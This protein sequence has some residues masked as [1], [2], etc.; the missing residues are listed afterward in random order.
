MNDTVLEASDMLLLPDEE[1]ADQEAV[2]YWKFLIVDDD[3]DIHRVTKL[4]LERH[5]FEGRKLQFMS[6]YS[7]SE[8][9]G[10]LGEHP[11]IAVV[12]LDVVMEQDDSGLTL[13]KVL[14]EVLGNQ[15]VRIILRTGQPGQAPEHTVIRAYDISDYKEKTELTST[16]LFST[17][18]TSIR[19]YQF[20][21]GV[22]ADKETLEE[23]V[24]ERTRELELR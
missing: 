22:V 18:Y 3:R 2:R 6:A 1:P 8:A 13:V 12:L 24:R 17:V 15:L 19:T 5:M 9:I 7:A 11:D 4:V 16:K 10:F 20:L 14:R 23:K 21:S